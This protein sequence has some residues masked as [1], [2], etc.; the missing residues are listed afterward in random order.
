MKL[1]LFALMIL[2]GFPVSIRAK[3]MLDLLEK[4]QG[5]I[6]RPSPVVDGT[7]SVTPGQTTTSG[8]SQCSSDEQK[9]IPLRLL[10]SLF[11]DPEGRLEIVHEPSTGELR[12]KTPPMISNCNDMIDWRVTTFTK[13]NKTIYALETAIKPGPKYKMWKMESKSPKLTNDLEFK[14]DLSGFEEC[15]KKSGVIAD[16]TVKKESIYTSASNHEFKNIS[17]TGDLLFVS[18]GPQFNTIGAKYQGVNQDQC[19]Y[20]EQI[21]EG[22]TTLLSLQDQ[23]DKSVEEKFNSVKDCGDYEK[24]ADFRNLHKE[25]DSLISP[26]IEELMEKALKES[27]A[28]IN[29][30]EYEDKDLEALSDFREIVIMP[31]T[32]RLAKLHEDMKNLSGEELSAAK[33]ESAEIKKKLTGYSKSPYL[34]SKLVAN[35]EAKGHFDE[36]GDVNF[37][38]ALVINYN[39]LGRKELGIDITP[40]VAEARANDQKVAFDNQIELKRERYEVATGQRAGRSEEYYAVIRNLASNIKLRSENYRAEMLK[41][42]KRIQSGVCYRPYR[43]PQKCI[44]KATERIKSLQAQLEFHNKKD[45]ELIAHYEE[46]AAEELELE[47]KG[48]RYLAAQNG[49]A[50]PAD[51]TPPDNLYPESTEDEE[52]EDP[53][54]Y[55]F[56]YNAGAAQNN[57]PTAQYNM[58]PSPMGSQYY[59]NFGY[60]QNPY[61]LYGNPQQPYPGSFSPYPYQQQPGMLQNPYQQGY[62]YP[63]QGYFN[64]PYQAY[65][66]QYFMN[67]MR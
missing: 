54:V 14:A 59:G 56:D 51:M 47:N 45:S 21:Q 8:A 13:D 33:K 62:Q 25:Y 49:E 60:A 35:L 57:Q 30:G 9:S 36:A 61:G 24:L 16:D 66:N 10:S 58:Q 5:T 53:G 3:S 29:K 52:T 38:N 26:I 11:L 15:L 37:S 67:G 4:H 39:K 20:F 2:L 27:V 19:R 42:A 65:S 44:L 7:T 18:E 32:D 43:N 34:D 63:Q 40:K 41:E 1:N 17:K 31:L 22:G 6:S 28:N 46:I 48:R 50:E 55:T 64:N 23:Q 12:I